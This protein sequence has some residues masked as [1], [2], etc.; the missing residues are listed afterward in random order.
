MRVITSDFQNFF[1]ENERTQ[2]NLLDRKFTNIGSFQT[3]SGGSLEDVTV[4]YETFGSLNPSRDNAILVCHAL[5]SDSHCTGWWERIV[6][7]NRAIDTNQYFV[8]C[9][10]VLGGCQGT[11]GPS[12]LDPSGEWYG[13]RFPI[14]TIRDMV[15][16][17]AKVLS[18]LGIDQLLAVAGGSMGGMQAIEWSRRHPSRVRK[19]FTTASAAAHSPMQ[20]GF[21]ETARQAIKRDPLWK[22]GNYYPESGPIQGL[23]VARMLGHLTFLSESSFDRKFGRRLQNG[24]DFKY[25]LGLEFEVESYL[26][27]QGDKFTDRFDANSLLYLTKAIDYYDCTSL[28]GSEAEY[29]FVSYSSDWIYPSHQSEQLNKLAKSFGLK[30]NHIEI[31]L[32]FGHDSF[33]LDGELQGAALS[34]FLKQ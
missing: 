31:D 27:H 5:S 1:Q 10:N 13:S 22:G 9:Q 23:A 32:P 16:V 21:N 17:Q 2:P 3:E 29:L 12:S 28:Q 34:E 4:A 24:K 8:I 20:I 25:H 15:D 30:S 14:L 26:K 18:E 7:P 6:G 33:L 11:T 19:V